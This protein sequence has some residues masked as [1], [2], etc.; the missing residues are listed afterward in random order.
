MIKTMTCL[1]V[2]KEFYS[3]IK[4]KFHDNILCSLG[5]KLAMKSVKF[6]IE[7]LKCLVDN[8]YDANFGPRAL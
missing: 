4:F 8:V 6:E 3:Y 1:K 2:Y 7:S 5:P